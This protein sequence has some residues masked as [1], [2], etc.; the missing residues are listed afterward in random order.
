[1]I[2]QIILADPT[3][4]D[5]IKSHLKKYPYDT[6]HLDETDIHIFLMYL[7]MTVAAQ[8]AFELAQQDNFI[9]EGKTHP[10]YLVYIQMS[11]EVKQL[12]AALLLT[13]KS[14]LTIKEVEP[15][16]LSGLQKFL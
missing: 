3:I 12:A 13:P 2:E 9:L 1:M 11:R 4:S 7:N 14:K 10:S 15:D 16:E 5:D 6:A 8:Q